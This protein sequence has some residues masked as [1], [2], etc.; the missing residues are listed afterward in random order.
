[1][2]HWSWGHFLA[3]S[4]AATSCGA[5]LYI[6]LYQS[7]LIKQVWCPIF[8]R[9]CELVADAPFA[10]PFGVPDGYIASGL[11]AV[12]ALWLFGPVQ[13]PWVKYPLIVFAFLALL[14][15]V[16]GMRDMTKL[17]QYCFYCLLTAVLSPLLLVAASLAA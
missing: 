14:A 9:G 3:L 7:R 10:W 13:S 16:Q 8:G 11:Y 15:N 5:M 2:I 12:I 4:L 17:G 1:M 6:G